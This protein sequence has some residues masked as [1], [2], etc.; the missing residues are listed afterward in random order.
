VGVEL[1]HHV[2]HHARALLGGTIEM[3]PH[4]VHHVERAPVDGFK[5]VAHV[6]QGAAHDHAHGVIEIRPPH[7]VFDVD[8]N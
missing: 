7:L 1:A 8:R 2:A 4:F 6:R 5:T 3:Q